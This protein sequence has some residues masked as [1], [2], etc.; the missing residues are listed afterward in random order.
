MDKEN[1][2][3][4]RVPSSIYACLV[5]AG[6]INLSDLNS[7]PEDFLWPSE[8]SWIFQKIFDCPAEFSELD[9]IE[10]V[11]DGLDT[12]CQ[13]WLNDRL[14]AKTDN[15]FCSYRFD[16][17]PLLEKKN[18]RLLVKCDSPLQEGNRLMKRFGML[19][20][21]NFSFSCRSYVRKAQ[22]QFG[23]D[24]APALPGCGI[25]QPVRIEGFSSS[26]LRDIHIR[27]IQADPR[28]AD[29]KVSV[30]T[31]KIAN[32]PSTI[33]RLTVLDPAGNIAAHTELDCSA[34]DNISTV[35]KIKPVSLWWPVSYG[36]QSLYTLRAELFSKNRLIETSSKKFGI[37]TAHLNQSPDETDCSFEFIVNGRRVYVRGAS[38][39]PVSLLAGSAAETDYERLL[40]AAKEANINMLR[41]WGGGIYETE[42]FYNLCDKLGIMVWQDFAFT[43]AYYPDRLWFTRM[44]KTEAAQN[45]T[46]LRNHPSLVLWCGNNEIDWSHSKGTLGKSR[47]F[48]GRDIYHKILFQLAN[49]LDPDRD[50]IPSTPFGPAKNPND[51]SSGTVHQWNVWSGLEPSD[52]YLKKI[53]RFTAEFGFQSL[54]CKKT[55]EDFLPDKKLHPASRQLEK[56]NYQPNGTA[57][58]HYYINELFR[59]PGDISEFIYLSQLTQARAVRKNVEH[60]RS[61]SNVNSGVLFW[62]FN[63]CRPAISWSCIDYQGRPKALYYYAKRCFAPVLTTVSAQYDSNRLPLEKTIASLTASIINHSTEPLTGLFTCRLSDMNLRIM[64]EFKRPVTLS[65]AAIISF[66]LPQSFV[67]PGQ[68][69]SRFLHLLLEN[70]KTVIA[71]NSF[72]YLPDKYINWPAAKTDFKS[73]RHNDCEWLLK[74]KSS[75]AVKDL[76]IDM[77]FDAQ[78]SDNFFDLLTDKPETVTIHTAE[79][80]DD[81]PE[82]ISLT[83]VNSILTG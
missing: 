53:P 6:L 16:I 39:I 25:W 72:F 68:P 3:N 80:I 47:K 54:P 9:R 32:Q 12:F 41:V 70:D 26:R 75:S 23:W 44:I 19:S 61:N 79:V 18:N 22:C 45:I 78:M 34:A 14:I 37:R 52:N 66:S 76:Y 60:L 21:D 5:E 8:K 71:Q 7:N 64:D 46:R 27:T 83:C 81:L 1:W 17:K 28:S 74:L 42:T 59:P 33:C 67:R 36:S 49:E 24:W 11:F 40:A 77:P 73:E 56:H 82:K 62:Q 57:R 69:E 15:M 4:C 48:Y 2:L 55:L 30:Q 31:E 50:Y 51:P 20:N 58:L 63:D 38:W 10:L 35:L 29:I 13:I 43:A 65:P